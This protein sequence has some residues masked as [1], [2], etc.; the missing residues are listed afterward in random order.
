LNFNYSAPRDFI[1]LLYAQAQAKA[2]DAYV[3]QPR[4]KNPILYD[5]VVRA[6]IDNEAQE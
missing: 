6:F 5:L 4:V 3:S 1:L 2:F